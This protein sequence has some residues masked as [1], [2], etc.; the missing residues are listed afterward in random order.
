MKNKTTVKD[1]AQLSGVSASTVSRYL[2][3][4]T[5][6]VK[7]KVDLIEKAIY[8]LNFVHRS[9]KNHST[10]TRS[11]MIGVIAPSYDSSHSVRILRGM[12]NTVSQ[13]SYQLKVEIT[14]WEQ[15]REV[16]LLEQFVKQGVDAIIL[17][18]GYLGDMEIKAITKEVPVLLFGSPVYTKLRERDGILPTLEI[19]NELGGYLATNHLLQLGHRRI[20]HIHGPL[21]NLDA[22]ERLK[23]YRRSIENAGIEFDESLLMDGRFESPYGLKAIEALIKKGVKFTAVFA[24]ND[25]SAFGVIQGLHRKGIKVPDD[26]SVVG[27]D[28]LPMC[29]YFV[30]SITTINQPFEDMGEIAIKTALDLISGNKSNYA[31]PVMNVVMREST[32]P[33]KSSQ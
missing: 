20:A 10:E 31:V 5:Y 21:D 22:R 2:N 32:D 13:T 33:L 18:G 25:E 1:I 14:H 7:E 16:H 11:M 26:V 4:S 6:I 28:D 3:R 24:G 15:E 8:E 30:P 12:E 9:R 29:T 19:D 23:G 27:F 17:V